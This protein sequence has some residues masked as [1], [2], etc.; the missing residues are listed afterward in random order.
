LSGGWLISASTARAADAPVGIHLSGHASNDNQ[1]WQFETMM[2]GYQSYE[3]FPI[4][5][6]IALDGGSS[7]LPKAEVQQ[8]LLPL[9]RNIL[10]RHYGLKTDN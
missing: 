1:S 5:K 9:W 10:R 7:K 6:E 4:P 2:E 3:G 8:K